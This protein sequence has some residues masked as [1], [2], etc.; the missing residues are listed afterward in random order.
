MQKTA[1]RA[2]VIE[3]LVSKARSAG[4]ASSGTG[5]FIVDILGYPFRK[6]PKV[7]EALRGYNLGIGRADVAAGKALEKIPGIGRM[8]RFTEEVPFRTRAV[9]KKGIESVV[10]SA[11]IPSARLTEPIRKAQAF[12]VPVLAYMGAESVMG[13]SGAPVNRTESRDMMSDEERLRLM[14]ANR[15]GV[16]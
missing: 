12:A 7:M 15:Y 11:K 16:Q 14:L 6:K 4:A 8:F 3:K 1:I 9:G 10:Q 5:S 2:S 13:E